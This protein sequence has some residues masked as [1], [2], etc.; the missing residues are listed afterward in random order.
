MVVLA[1]NSYAHEF[2][3]PDYETI[4]K[5]ARTEAYNQL[6]NRFQALDTTLTLDDLQTL[7]YGSI[8]VEKSSFNGLPKETRKLLEDKSKTN[9]AA[10]AI[11]RHL[12]KYPFDL[13]ALVYR[14]I[15]A[16]RNNDTA[17][18]RALW[19]KAELVVAAIVSTGNGQTDS[20]GFHVVSVSDEYALMDFFFE[21]ERGNQHLTASQCDMF[22]ITV[23]GS[24]S[25]LYFDIQ[26]LLAW[27]NRVFNGKNTDKP[28]T[29]TYDTMVWSKAGKSHM[30][31]MTL[32]KKLE[33]PQITE[34]TTSE[35]Y[36]AYKP[37]VIECMKWL[38]THDPSTKNPEEQLA[39]IDAQR[40]IV[41]WCSGVDG[42]MFS[43]EKEFFSYKMK[44]IGCYFLGGWASYFAKTGDNDGINGRIAGIEAVIECYNNFPNAL[45]K[46]KKKILNFKK[47]QEDGTLRQYVIDNIG[48][49][50]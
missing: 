1:V 29:F 20:T 27:E 34:E 12:D 35:E 43:L 49:L 15:P 40:F 9:I 44:E 8:F 39:N 26:A 17:L 13:Q 31:S 25:N 7:Y 11:D 33:L 45:K 19:M 47:M 30:S 5:I 3:R 41:K 14:T 37:K 28:F 48:N 22:D 38:Q 23:N 50:R 18:V 21:V 2:Q 4:Q 16:G 36:D 42:C 46:D 24:E 32:N 10:E 6:L